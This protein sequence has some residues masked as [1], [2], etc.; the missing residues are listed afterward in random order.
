MK[1]S[2][3]KYFNS[4]IFKEIE[5]EM[6][7]T[8]PF[9]LPGEDEEFQA[10]CES[11]RTSLCPQ[12]EVEKMLIDQIAC[13]FLKLRRLR[14][15]ERAIFMEY[16]NS[17]GIRWRDILEANYLE[18]IVRYERRITNYLA[19]LYCKF[20]ERPVLDCPNSKR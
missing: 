6:T 19:E 20:D 7:A 8:Q 2:K 1:N 12:N 17:N 13:S 9:L 11:I 5:R 14:V 10:I 16:S 4:A 3:T 18:K 15:M